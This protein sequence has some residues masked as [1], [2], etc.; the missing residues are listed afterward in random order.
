MRVTIEISADLH[1]K[2]KAAAAKHGQSLKQFLV[3]TLQERISSSSPQPK[4]E[5]EWMKFF[6]AFGKTAAQHAENRRIE[7]VIEEAF[8]G[9]MR[10]ATPVTF[11]SRQRAR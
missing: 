4:A 2:T 11:S 7:R 1:R 9:S 10:R 6:G 5:P 8:D 3:E